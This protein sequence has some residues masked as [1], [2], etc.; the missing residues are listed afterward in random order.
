HGADDSSRID[1][2]A[3]N[4]IDTYI[5]TKSYDTDFRLFLNGA[6]TL[7][8]PPSSDALALSYNTQLSKI[9]SLSDEIIYHPVKY[10]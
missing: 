3:S 6:G 1:P 2:S 7:P 10:K 4:L 5:L 9:K 8:L